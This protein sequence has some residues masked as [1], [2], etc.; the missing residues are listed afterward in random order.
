MPN[1]FNVTPRAKADLR[2]IWLY[3]VQTWNEMQADRYITSLFNRFQWLAERP[4]VGKHRADI[5]HGYYCFPQAQHL[6]FYIIRDK[7]IDIIGIP[8]SSMDVDNLFEE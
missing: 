6:I 8:H 3:T 2:D 7:E 4:Q 5:E 1:K